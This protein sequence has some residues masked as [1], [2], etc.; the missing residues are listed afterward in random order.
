MWSSSQISS[1]HVVGKR[2]DGVEG[3]HGKKLWLFEV[4]IQGIYQVYIYI[5][6]YTRYI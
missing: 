1:N 4:Y 5:Y 6:I 3:V 2:V